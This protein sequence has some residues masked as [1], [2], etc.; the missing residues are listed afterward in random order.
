MRLAS[1]HKLEDQ[2]VV[3]YIGLHLWTLALGGIYLGDK[4]DIFAWQWQ[5]F[6]YVWDS[7]MLK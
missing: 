4:F 2:D 5:Y 1:T 7:E 6:E 3:S